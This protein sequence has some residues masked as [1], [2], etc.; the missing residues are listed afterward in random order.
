[1][2]Y[3]WLFIRHSHLQTQNNMDS[4]FQK[5][6]LNDDNDYFLKYIS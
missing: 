4:D 3:D 2:E 6:I 5:Q 1:M